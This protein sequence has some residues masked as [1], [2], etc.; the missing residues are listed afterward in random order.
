MPD[1][2]YENHISFNSVAKNI[3][4]SAKGN[5]Q[6]MMTRH[7]ISQAT[8]QGMPFQSLCRL[9]YASGSLGGCFRVMDSNKFPELYQI[10]PGSRQEF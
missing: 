4:G 2:D 6:I 5:N 7:I 9:Q 1:S 8:E 3:P 10:A